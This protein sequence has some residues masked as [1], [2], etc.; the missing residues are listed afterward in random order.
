MRAGWYGRD[1]R[2]GPT[3]TVTPGYGTIDLAGGWSATSNIEVRMLL[4][5]I[6]DQEYP[7]SS[8]EKAVSAPGRSVLLTVVASMGG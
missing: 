2:P 7:G 6:F 3:E 1:D 4:G 8:D 5:N